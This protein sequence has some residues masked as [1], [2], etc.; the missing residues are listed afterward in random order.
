MPKAKA[1]G[2]P[3]A[4]QAPTIRMKKTNRLPNFIVVSCGLKYQSSRLTPPTTSTASR[5]LRSVVVSTRRK[6]AM[7]AASDMPIKSILVCRNE[8][9]DH[10]GDHDQ[11][12]DRVEPL[13]KAGPDPVDERR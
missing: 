7:T 2:T 4:T 9:L 6:M 11:G 10:K 8:D 12:G 5:K 1:I 13:T 3:M